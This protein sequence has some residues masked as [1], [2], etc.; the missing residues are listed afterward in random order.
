MTSPELPPRAVSERL[1]AELA[2]LRARLLRRIG[3]AHRGPV[4]DLGAGWGIVTEELARRARGPVVAVDRHP[5]ALAA[6]G[7]RGMPGELSKLPFERDSFDLVFCQQVLMWQRALDPV[8][9][10][11]RRVLRPG[12]AVIAIEPDHGATMEH[13][14]EIAIAE[15]WRAALARA[16]AD[17]CVG[18][19]LP[20]AFATAGFTVQI[21]LPP[22]P[23][24]ADTDR[25]DALEGLPLSD[26]ERARLE[27][28]RRTQERLEPRDCFV[29]VPFVCVTAELR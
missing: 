6:L 17:P 9:R 23:S 27:A 10:E 2:P 11:V 7:A 25:F 20:P 19:R 8:V 15:V 22:S 3:V 5:A 21:D 12:G 18:R 4:L 24:P 1:A 29:H 28:A 13:P 26:E 16:G 14:P